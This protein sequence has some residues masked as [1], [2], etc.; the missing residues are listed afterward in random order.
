MSQSH[1]DTDKAEEVRSGSNRDATA[2][3]KPAGSV[4]TEELLENLI[5]ETGA[6]S[7]EGTA[8]EEPS[9]RTPLAR[10][11]AERTGEIKRT[12][13]GKTG[14]FGR[15]AA[16]K[17]GELGRV[18]A[19]KSAGIGRTVARLDVPW[20]RGRSAGLVREAIHEF[21]IKP[22]I[23]FYTRPRLHGVERLSGAQPPVIFAANHSSHLDAPTILRALPRRWR[24]RT[25]VAAA[26]DYFYKT[27]AV[28]NA[29]ALVFNTVPL[30][31]S[32]GGLGKNSTS[33][34]DKL[35]EDRWSLLM[36]PE[37]TR[38]RDGRIGKLR[39]GAAVIAAHHDIPIVP[40][41]VRGTYD[42]MPPGQTWPRR[43]PGRFVSRRHR[44]DVYFGDP[45][46]P[47]EMRSRDEIME[48]VRAFFIEHAG[49]EGAPPAR[50]PRLRSRRF[51]GR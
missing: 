49:E 24:R 25:A 9:R 2:Q 11:A 48:R 21:A 42:A 51:R 26:A 50:S 30:A 15:V 33:H 17:T 1:V 18:A 7:A 12:A 14:E 5:S 20:A 28:G 29:F 31:R 27:R 46:R 36:F 4:G 34:V 47:A 38:S 22:V 16:G 45:V 13:V 37:G 8:D 19:S 39:T 10:S 43:I 41:Y 40:I 6:R 35:I 23:T 44:V 3:P 32:G